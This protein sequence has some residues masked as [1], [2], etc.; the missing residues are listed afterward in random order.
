MRVSS[1]VRLE[2][3]GDTPGGLGLFPYATPPFFNCK[4]GFFKKMIL[5]F[6]AELKE[7]ILS[8]L[9]I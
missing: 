8:F 3:G 2:Q 6:F 1:G 4:G 5:W 9:E 7:S